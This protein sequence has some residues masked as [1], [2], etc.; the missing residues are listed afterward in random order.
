MT[1]NELR[2]L[3]LTV[4]PPVSHYHA[5]KQPDSY[6]VWAEY[7]RHKL[8]ADNQTIASAVQVQVD[9][10]TKTELDPNVEKITALLDTDEISFS[11]LVDY[12]KDTGYIHHIWDCEVS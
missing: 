12:E 8:I 6:I 3:L 4:G 7:G 11:Y 2:D 1:L 9:Y 10:F 5:H